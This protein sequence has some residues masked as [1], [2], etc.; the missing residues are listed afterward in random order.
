M[1]TIVIGFPG[2]GKT[3]YCRE[4][5]GDG[6]C[7]D[8]D[9]ISSAFRLGKVDNEASRTMAND[10]LEGFAAQAEEYSDDVFIIRTAPNTREI[11]DIRPDKVVV[12]QTIYG[13]R[14]V[15][16]S[17]L[18]LQKLH[19]AIEYCRKNSIPIVFSS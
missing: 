16:N 9:A 17:D 5:M 4:H 3:T 11:T 8:L 14:E 12:C 19:K 7:Y 10:F 13:H 2:T 18:I 1:I 6:I 15:E